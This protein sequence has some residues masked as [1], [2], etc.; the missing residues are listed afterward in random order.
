VPKQGELSLTQRGPD[1]KSGL[2]ERHE[3][4]AGK[5]LPDQADKPPAVEAAGKQ[6]KGAKASPGRGPA[7]VSLPKDAVLRGGDKPAED[8]PAKTKHDAR[9]ADAPAAKDQA[10]Q[11]QKPGNSAAPQSAPDARKLMI[12]DG[13]PEQDTP[14]HNGPGFGDLEM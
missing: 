6:V 10:N 7:P 14:S 2:R 8:D 11:A 12:E 9:R 1:D 13:V 4:V 3:P 5:S